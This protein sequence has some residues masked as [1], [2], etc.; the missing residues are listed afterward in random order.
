MNEDSN[1]YYLNEYERRQDALDA[2]D[3]AER[4]LAE[5]VLQSIEKRYADLSITEKARALCLYCSDELGDVTAV[6]E[7]FVLGEIGDLED[8]AHETLEAACYWYA[9]TLVDLHGWE[10]LE[11]VEIDAG[12]EL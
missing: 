6:L 8:K 10:S 2:R 9:S 11:D 12:R 4:E 3:W 1:I 7:H 5:Q